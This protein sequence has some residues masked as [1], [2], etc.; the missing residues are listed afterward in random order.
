MPVLIK[1]S[2]DTSARPGHRSGSAEEGRFLRRARMVKTLIV[3]DNVAFRRAL[4]RALL[5]HFPKMA[6]AE[7]SK[8]REAREQIQ[9]FSPTLVFMDI[10]LPNGNGLDLTKEIKS[11]HPEILVIV[12]TSYDLHE[13]QEAAL[14]NGASYFLTK[15]SVTGETIAELIRSMAGP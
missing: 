2:M 1:S 3:E 8:S 14:R 7:A 11:A 10:R 4:T 12:L 9:H 15:G 13:Y 6:I 5:D